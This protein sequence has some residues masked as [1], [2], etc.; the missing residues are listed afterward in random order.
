MVLPPCLPQRA[1]LMHSPVRSGTRPAAVLWSLSR[2]AAPGQRGT[3]LIPEPALRWHPAGRA[4]RRVIARRPKVG[5]QG[6][7]S[8]RLP[9]DRWPPSPLVTAAHRR[10]PV[11]ASLPSQHINLPLCPP[12]CSHADPPQAPARSAGSRGHRS[13]RPAAQLGAA[14]RRSGEKHTE[15]AFLGRAVSEGQ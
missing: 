1:A 11:V 15:P 6:N 13:C 10:C 8:H 7:R 12:S 2:R 4:A 5:Q 9:L 3:V 14:S